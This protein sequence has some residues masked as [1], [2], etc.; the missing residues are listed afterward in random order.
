MD[1]HDGFLSTSRN[2]KK[3][4]ILCIIIIGRLII[5]TLSIVDVILLYS[6]VSSQKCLDPQAM[7]KDTTP[8]LLNAQNFFPPGA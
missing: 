2:T 4:K 6:L 7:K 8:R 3:T 5:L 1:D